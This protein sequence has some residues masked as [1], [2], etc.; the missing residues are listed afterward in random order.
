MAI[1]IILH[2][3]SRGPSSIL[4]FTTTGLNCCNIG[5][6]V[7]AIFHGSQG[8]LIVSAVNQVGDYNTVKVGLELEKWHHIEIAQKK[9][10]ISGKV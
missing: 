8:L 3:E 7:P 2:S 4:R 9:Y 6:R 10:H 5:D 1:D